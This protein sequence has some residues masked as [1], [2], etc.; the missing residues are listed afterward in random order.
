M[1]VRDAMESDGGRLAELADVPTEVMS[2][3]VHDRTVC[4]AESNEK[5]QGFVGFDAYKD[6]V[7][8]THLFGSESACER[9]LDEPIRFAENEEMTVEMLLPEAETDTADVAED[10][11][12]E[13]LG[14]GPR[15]EDQQT[16][17]FRLEN[18]EAAA[19]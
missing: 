3:V 2:N 14:S 9:L 13:H 19:E 18:P 7:H 11:G 17:R 15:F 8:V 16:L 10:V 5:I 4:V 6:T 1:H 12:F